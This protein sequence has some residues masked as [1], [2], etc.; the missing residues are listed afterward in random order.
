MKDDENITFSDINKTSQKPIYVVVLEDSESLGQYK[1]D[2]AY[3][4]R[5]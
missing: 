2:L 4:A 3:K 1:E 5:E